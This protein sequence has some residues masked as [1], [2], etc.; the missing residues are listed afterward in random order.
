MSMPP[1]PPSAPGDQPP[2]WQPTGTPQPSYQPPPANP[3]QPGYAPGYAA[4]PGTGAPGAFERTTTP[5]GWVAAALS[6]A[7]AVAPFLPWAKDNDQDKT[8]NGF[9]EILS[10]RESEVQAMAGAAVLVFAVIAAILLVIG[11]ATRRRVLHI[12]GA[13]AIG[14]A[15][16]MPFVD[17]GRISD[18]NDLGADVDNGPGI[19]V[20]IATGL[21]AMVCAII[22][23]VKTK[24]RP[25]GAGY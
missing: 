14:I 16:F 7:C 6:V 11:T 1:P 4:Q 8:F 23:A 25:V 5:L 2:S 13:I 18:L 21:I 12:L 24:R 15:G 19:W 22:A 17:I 10:V 9:G 20:A 3:S